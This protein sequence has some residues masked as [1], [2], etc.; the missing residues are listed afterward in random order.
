MVSKLLIP[1]TIRI[2]ERFASEVGEILNRKTMINKRNGELF[3]YIESTL[4]EDRFF[5]ETI[6]RLK[7]PN[8]K[9]YFVVLKDQVQFREGEDKT[10][11]ALGA[12]HRFYD[13]ALRQV[14]RA[15]LHPEFSI[16]DI[17]AGFVVTEF[18]DDLRS[19]YQRWEEDKC[20]T[21]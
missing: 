19:E 5:L 4:E 21:L 14:N 11:V 9:Y 16:S 15:E 7:H 20:I 6:L 10:V 17:V 18:D 12:L 2:L 1:M 8:G 3:P 13:R